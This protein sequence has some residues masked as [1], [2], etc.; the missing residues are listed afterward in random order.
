M[1]RLHI[2]LTIVLTALLALASRTP[3]EIPLAASLLTAHAYLV[4]IR[5]A[6]WPT[7]VSSGII[8]ASKLA[9]EASSER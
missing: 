6:I 5:G 1:R 7:L 8:K 3:A 4:G 9:W 2:G